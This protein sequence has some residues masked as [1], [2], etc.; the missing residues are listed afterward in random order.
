E[1]TI[2][3]TVGCDGRF[4]IKHFGEFGE[5]Q[6]ILARE[7]NTRLAKYR[8][9]DGLWYGIADL[10]IFQSYEA[11]I[12]HITRLGLPVLIGFCRKIW[13]WQI[14]IRI[15]SYNICLIRWSPI[16]ECRRIL[17]KPRTSPCRCQTPKQRSG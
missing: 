5:C 12:L 6:Q 4:G 7:I 11:C 15:R 3:T 8:T 9:Y 16:V 1:V 13:L 14:C 10:Q 2:L 17:V